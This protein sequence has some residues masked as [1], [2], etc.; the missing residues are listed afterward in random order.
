MHRS[1][2]RKIQNRFSQIPFNAYQHVERNMTIEVALHWPQVSNNVW[3]IMPHVCNRHCRQLTNFQCFYKLCPRSDCPHLT[4][5]TVG[6]TKSPNLHGLHHPSHDV[7]HVLRLPWRNPGRFFLPFR[8]S[9]ITTGA[10]RTR[11]TTPLQ[12][13]DARNGNS[14]Q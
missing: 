14:R 6:S 13:L 12:S 5:E 4:L 8:K 11:S 2:V 10:E 1:Q 7:R 3:G 9:Y